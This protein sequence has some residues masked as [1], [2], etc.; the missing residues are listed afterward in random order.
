[1]IDY[2]AIAESNNFIV[3]DKYTQNWQVAENYQSEDDLER[4][5]VQ[6]LV[7]QGYEYLPALN[8]PQAMLANVREQLQAL[9]KVTFSEG[10]WQR[11][12]E[13]YLVKPSDSITD[14]TRK[15][16]DDYILDFVFDDGR[17]QNIYLADKNNITRNKLQVIKQFEQSGSQANRYDVT[18]LVNGLPL[19]HIELKKRGVAIREA[20]NQVHRYSKESFNSD[21][22]LYKYL[23]LFVISNGTDTRYFAN[24][25][26][27]DK[28]SF[29]F[30]MNWAKADNSLI[31]DLK[32]FT[33]TFFQKNTLL[34]VLLHYSVFDVSDTLLVMRPYQIAATERI[35]WKIKSAYEAKNWSTPES[36][37]YI[38]HTTGSGKTLTSFKAARIATEL[39][40]INKV[41]FIVDRKDLDYQTMKEYQRFSPDSVNGSDSTAGLRRNLDK[42]D[43]KIVVTTIQKLNNLMKGEANLPIYNKQVVFIFDE[44]HRSQ[45]GEA[46]KNL[47][48]KFKRYYQFGFTGTPIFPQNALGAETTASVFGRELHSYVI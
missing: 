32:D 16:H 28:N 7:N 42:D 29:D 8:N 17:I 22:S 30:S 44:C 15:I 13:T 26:K 41:F 19:V 46:Q 2:K 25:T 3:L 27:R 6:D 24:T 21:N 14:K 38:W 35:L 10:E 18:I 34:N 23:Q 5:L 20:F 9:N 36:G 47:Q 33:A 1:M 37:G 45:F 4:E 12:V 43:N 11:F 40:F 48:K 39:E 31:K